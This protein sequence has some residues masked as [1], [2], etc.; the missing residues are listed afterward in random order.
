[1][2]IGK[3]RDLFHTTR[4]V[5]KLLHHP[6]QVIKI[7]LQYHQDTAEHILLIDTFSAL[8]DHIRWTPQ[9][10]S[11][12]QPEAMVQ[13][14][15]EVVRRGIPASYLSTRKRPGDTSLLLCTLALG[16]VYKRRTH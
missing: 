5:R 7:G 14:G 15:T 16:L 4:D 12:T 3:A 13:L 1:M 8:G 6:H 10:M 11:D 9:L 2:A